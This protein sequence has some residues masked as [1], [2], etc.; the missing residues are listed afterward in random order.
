MISNSIKFDEYE[1]K[2]VEL[3]LYFRKKWSD[4]QC[5][6]KDLKKKNR[7]TFGAREEAETYLHVTT[8]LYFTIIPS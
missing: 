2:T 3:A 8:L 4:A 7:I 5:G 1:L 6:R